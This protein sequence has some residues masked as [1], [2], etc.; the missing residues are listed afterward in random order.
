LIEWLDEIVIR[1]SLEPFNPIAY[2][3]ARS[4]NNNR[5][6]IPAAAVFSGGPSLG[7]PANEGRVATHR[8]VLT[9]KQHP[10][11]RPDEPNRQRAQQPE[12][13]PE[14]PNRC[15]ARPRPTKL[16][17]PRPSALTFIGQLAYPKTMAERKTASFTSMR[18]VFRAKLTAGIDQPSQ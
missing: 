2:L 6:R 3:I 15:V 11:R 7:H 9:V 14:L 17:S 8:K 4:Q 16:A 13:A 12:H 10:R 1:S 5:K 18:I